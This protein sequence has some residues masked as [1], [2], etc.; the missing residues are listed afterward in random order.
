MIAHKHGKAASI[1]DA[2]AHDEYNQILQK[3]YR[4]LGRRVTTGQ[5][6]HKVGKRILGKSFIGVYP[7][8]TVPKTLKNGDMMIINTD[9]AKGKGQH[10]IAAYVMNNTV[11]IY[12]SFGRPSPK[13]LP[14]FLK[15]LKHRYADSDG[16]AEQPKKSE[17]CGAR[18]MAWL[19]YAK[20]DLQKAMRI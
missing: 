15:K 4:T 3:M 19:L 20:Q 11:H 16:D 7:Q 6:L 5:Q 10:W 2:Q 13:V 12:D 1:G 14:M 18:S 17:D 8:D 9:V